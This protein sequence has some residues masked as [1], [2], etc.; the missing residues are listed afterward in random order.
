M[1]AAPGIEKKLTTTLSINAPLGGVTGSGRGLNPLWIKG[2]APYVSCVYE[3]PEQDTL[4]GFIV[5]GRGRELR[6]ASSSGIELPAY[7][8]HYE[9]PCTETVPDGRTGGGVILG[10]KNPR[11]D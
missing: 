1:V 4:M 6:T 9:A 3:H 8:P 10:P 7:G 2:H 5:E 11:H